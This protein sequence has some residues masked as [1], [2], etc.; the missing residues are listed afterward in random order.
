MAEEV[1]LSM[2]QIFVYVNQLLT[3]KQQV[4]L[5]SILVSKALKINTV[6]RMPIKYSFK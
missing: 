5:V 3:Y 6:V 2:P 4:I 1:G